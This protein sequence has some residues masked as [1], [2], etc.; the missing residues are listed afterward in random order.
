M[1]QTRL[2]DLTDCLRAGGSIIA[3]VHDFA[4]LACSVGTLLLVLAC[5]AA[6]GSEDNTSNLALRLSCTD[7]NRVPETLTLSITNISQ[8]LVRLPVPTMICTDPYHGSLNLVV[9]LLR[10]LHDGPRPPGVG[11]GCGVGLFDAPRGQQR[12]K[13]WRTLKQRQ[14]LTFKLPTD[15][16]SHFRE[17]GEYEYSVVYDPPDV[18]VSERRLLIDNHERFPE[19]E[20]TSNACVVKLR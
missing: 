9:C 4:E 14:S 10:R 11:T 12:L 16:S 1:P 20:M 7:T 6:F 18:D 3:I 17:P 8:A 15:G 5:L 13:D 19:R 2:I